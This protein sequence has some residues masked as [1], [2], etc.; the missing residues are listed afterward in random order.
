[1]LVVNYVQVSQTYH[2]LNPEVSA[3]MEQTHQLACYTWLCNFTSLLLIILFSTLTLSKTLLKS[4]AK[5]VLQEFLCHS[6]T[7]SL[8]TATQ[9]T[10]ANAV[11]ARV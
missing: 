9:Q 8:G 5:I 11:F 1:M 4:Q 7:L 3:E 6:V 10:S 2:Q